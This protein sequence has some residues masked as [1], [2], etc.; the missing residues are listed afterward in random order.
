MRITINRKLCRGLR[1]VVLGSA[2]LMLA[3]CASTPHP[4]ANAMDLRPAP[5]SAFVVDVI[6]G[7]TLCEIAVRYRV[8]M[9]DIVAINELY[10]I[11][12]L[13]PGQRLYV[14]AYGLGSNDPAPRRVA[15][16]PS[17]RQ[18]STQRSNNNARSQAVRPA[19]RLA[20]IPASRPS[21]T[22]TASS[23]NVRFLWPVDGP[24]LSSFGQSPN[25]QRNDGINIAAP[26]GTPIRAAEGGTVSYVGNELKGYGNLLLIRHDNG[27]VTAYAHA[28]RI[29]VARGDRVDRGQLVGYSGAT[30]DVTQPQLHFE[31]RRGT[32]PVNPTAY[33]G[34]ANATQA[35][36]VPSSPARS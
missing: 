27:F 30:G 32:R 9:E 26:R 12:R 22:R 24:V 8:H 13:L 11:D 2:A 6:R 7:D 28:D 16:A 3:N 21:D 23:T 18:V 1:L 20:T 25:G 15:Q 5:G 19:P 33:L 10:D 4:R 31:I 29:L 14:P 34:A 36:L 35:S 17:P